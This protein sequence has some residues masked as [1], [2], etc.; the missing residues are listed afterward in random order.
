MKKRFLLCAFALIC[1]SAFCSPQISNVEAPSQVEIFDLFEVSFDMNPYPNPYDPEVIDAYAVFQG[2]GNQQFKVNA[3]YFEDY[4]FSNDEG[5]ETYDATGTTGWRIRFT[6]NS[7]GTWTYTLHATD[8]QGSASTEQKQFVCNNTSHASGFISKANSRFIKQTK[9]EGG[10]PK[11]T[12]FFPV[13]PNISRYSCEDYGHFKQPYGIYEY[14]GYIDTL[15]GNGNY[16]RIFINRYPFLSLYG[17]EYT[18]GVTYFDSTINQKDSRELDLIIDYAKAHGVSVM[19]CFFSHNDFVSW[20]FYHDAPDN[21]PINPFHTFIPSISRPCDF[22]SDPTA[23]RIVKNL[24]RYIV[25]RWGYATNIMAWEFWNEVNQMEKDE[26]YF[27]PSSKSCDLSQ[28]CES[29]PFR[30]DVIDWHRIMSQYL[31]DIDPFHHLITTSFALSLDSNADNVD[32]LKRVY[33]FDAID[34][35]QSHR[36]KDADNASDNFQNDLFSIMRK[37]HDI[38]GKPSFVGEFGFSHFGSS[39][40]H[41]D[42]WGIEYHNSLWS[43]SFSGAIGAASLWWWQ[44]VFKNPTTKIYTY[45]SPVYRFLNALPPLSNSFYPY[46]NKGALGAFPNGIETYYLMNE[47][48]DTVYGWAHD[49]D[50]R[51]QKLKKDAPEYVSTLDPAYRPQPSSSNNNITISIQSQP[52]GAQYLIKWYDSESGDEFQSDIVYVTS[53]GGDKVLSFDFPS[54]VRDIQNNMIRNRFGDVVYAIYLNCDENIWWQSRLLDQDSYEIGDEIVCNKKTAQVFYKTDNNQIHSIWCNNAENTWHQSD[55]NDAATDV[56]KDLV[57]ADDGSRIFYINTNDDISSIYF[58]HNTKRWVHDDMNHA[59]NGNVQGPLAVKD[60]N[61]VFYR[62]KSGALNALWLDSQTHRWR[63]TSLNNAATHVGD[64]IAVSPNQ[65]QV[66]YKTKGK[67]LKAIQYDHTTSQWVA[68]NLNNCANSGVKGPITITPNNQVFFRTTKNHINSIYYN[69]SV[70]QRSALNNAA[71]NVWSTSGSKKI[72]QADITGKVFYINNKKQVDC[73][74]WAPDVEW[75]RFSLPQTEHNVL[76]LATNYDS[77]VYFLTN[78][79]NTGLKKPQIYRF[80]YKSQCYLDDDPL[81]R[82]QNENDDDYMLSEEMDEETDIDGYACS[83]QPV[84]TIYPNPTSGSITISSTSDIA[85]VYVFDYK[86]YLVASY[87][88]HRSSTIIIDLSSYRDGLYLIRT[89]NRNGYS[90]VTKINKID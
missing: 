16:F 43:S 7:V 87:D 25:S 48:C 74:Y 40:W 44:Y 73:I 36:Y 3:F 88:N 64:A 56:K 5:Y 39:H 63:W 23:I 72:L 60:S 77:N 53:S 2:P 24:I 26:T 19:P 29:E 1:L 80:H 55:L 13:G 41:K 31:R 65:S 22:F 20:E 66:F 18:T 42:P 51:F 28:Y 30:E 89:Q 86:G 35:A 90:T 78:I 8:S 81:Y 71:T 68:M 10:Q 38:T 37:T 58:D 49:K 4:T 6:P 69:G 54:S 84:V 17:K 21:W 61:Q 70:W 14:F 45:S 57:I 34:I 75:S 59:S 15:A 12:L 76:S 27:C 85:K 32:F 62:N 50:F 33:A 47:A 46:S 67:G 79:S 83:E 52:V 11:E 9:I 82:E